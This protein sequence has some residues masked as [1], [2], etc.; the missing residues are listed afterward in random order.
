VASCPIEIGGGVIDERTR[1]EVLVELAEALGDGGQPISS[2]EAAAQAGELAQS[3]GWNEVLSRAALSFGGHAAIWA[4]NRDRRGRALARAAL[5]QSVP[6]TISHTR[7]LAKL[8]S[9]SVFSLPATERLIM[10]AQVLA[11]VEGLGD[12]ALI[13][14]I[15]SE[16]TWAF[17]PNLRGPKW[18]HALELLAGVTDTRDARGLFIVSRCRGQAAIMVGDGQGFRAAVEASLPL[19]DQLS[20]ADRSHL[21]AQRGHVAI[22]DGDFL[23]AERYYEEAFQL[24]R[25]ELRD[26]AT[27]NRVFALVLLGWL[28]GDLSPAR[29]AAADLHAGLGGPNTEAVYMW[30]ELACGKREPALK[31]LASFGERHRRVFLT[32]AICG[33]GLAASTLASV[34]LGDR[35]IM[36]K[37]DGIFE[38][39]GF[40]IFTGSPPPA[41]A[42]AYYRG[43]LAHGLGDLERA[44]A[45][46]EHSLAVHRRL[47]AIPYIAASQ[48]ALAEVFAEQRQHA[49]AGRLAAA[50]LETAER[51]AAWGVARQARLALERLP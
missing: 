40:E 17:D 7:L 32:S 51:I 44:A 15:V 38:E 50:A 13:Q 16:L 18:E 20:D 45:L 8:A 28:R 25:G 24:G 27:G 49:E 34:A 36:R 22:W 29:L 41:L 26:T 23:A 47:P 35:E 37:V 12:R 31:F 48:A 39:L 10:A 2:L 4:L 19:R 1:A 21:A 14:R 30:V 9:L 11:G 5:E 42:V 46:L 3:H 43:I 6:G 33:Q